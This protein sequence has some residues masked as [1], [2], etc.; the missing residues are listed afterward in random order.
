MIVGAGGHAQVVADILLHM[1]EEE[2]EVE[3]V[4]YLDDNPALTGQELLGLPVAGVLADLP[5]I[6]HDAVV[7]AIGDN[8]TRR[9]VFEDLKAQGECFVVA[10]HPSAVVA[11]DVVVGPGTMICAGAVVNP[12][13]VVGVNV[14]LNTGCTVDHHNR[15]GDHVHLAPGVHTG[16][17]VTVGDG[18]F[19]GIGATIIPGRTIGP[20][21]TIGAASVVTKDIAPGV[22]AV[23]M[24]ARVIAH[25]A[26]AADPRHR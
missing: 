5:S 15:V 14:I 16:G 1:A 12:G 6:P 20:W 25:R 11:A 18:V 4:G 10:C 2:A 13:S 9:R 23:G 3:P 17:E 8:A 7:V 19:V 22:S 24:P 26:H 21:S